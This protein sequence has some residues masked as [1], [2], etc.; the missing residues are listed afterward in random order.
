MIFGDGEQERD[1]VFVHD[2]VLANW[3]ASTIPLPQAGDLDARAWNIGT[4]RGTSV[5][6]LAELLMRIAGG[7]VERLSA[8]ERPG[9]VARSVLECSRAAAELGWRAETELEEG[10]KQTMEH[11]NEESR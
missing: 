1:Y 3:L 6:E 9:E 5:N 2:V 4:G 11:L 7:E 8:P 10:L